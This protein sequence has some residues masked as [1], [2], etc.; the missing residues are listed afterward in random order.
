MDQ[1]QRV[2]AFCAYLRSEGFTPTIDDDGDVRFKFE[3]RYYYVLT[4]AADAEYFRLFH[5]VW[6]VDPGDEAFC[7]D[8]AN[9]LTAE[10]KVVKVYVVGTAVMASVE[11]FYA[12]LTAYEPLLMRLL[13]VCQTAAL[14]FREAV[15]RR[16]P[17]PLLFD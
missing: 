3:G 10:L 5:V 9:Q 1:Q 16:N 12:P 15:L 4:D 6:T 14:R 8:L 13:G 17:R 11:A 2:E 7:R